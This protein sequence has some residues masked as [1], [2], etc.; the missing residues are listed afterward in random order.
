MSPIG[1]I[2][3]MSPISLLSPLL[4]MSFPFFNYLL[5]INSSFFIRP[6]AAYQLC[7]V[8]FISI[9]VHG[10]TAYSTHPISTP[11]SSLILNT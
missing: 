8:W 2:G 9:S 11:P 1:L 6:Q 10:V 5:F 7:V 4:T 3:P